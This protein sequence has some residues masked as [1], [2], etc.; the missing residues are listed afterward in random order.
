M[1]Y[2]S[3]GWGMSNAPHAYTIVVGRD[4][5]WMCLGIDYVAPWF[6]AEA[7]KVFRDRQKPNGQ[8][9]EY[10]DMES[11]AVDDYG[12]NLADNTPLYAWA[13]NQHWQHFAE[14]GFYTAF[15]PSMQRAGAYLLD[16]IGPDDLLTSIPNG[17]GM[18]GITSWRNIIDGAVIAGQVTEI[19]A[20]AVL[21]LRQIAAFTGESHFATAAERIT[22]AINAHL[23][24]ETHYLL[25][26]SGEARNAQ[27]TGDQVF[28]L[29]AGVA[30]RERHLA[31]L[32]RLWQADFRSERGLRTVPTIDP[33]YSPT[34]HFG[35][36][37]GSW[38]N[39]TLWYA[40]VAAEYGPD[41]A[42]AAL[43]MVGYPV[44]TEQDAAMN[45]HPGEFPE[46]FHG[47]SGENLGMH[48]SPWVAP[49]FIWALLEGLLGLTWAHGT[50][51]FAPHWPDGWDEV[52]ITRLPTGMGE[53]DV[54]LTPAACEI[55]PH[56]APV[57]PV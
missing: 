56:A 32:D 35:L 45:I 14:E 12:L 26:R 21:G 43:E 17:T 53:V 13:V 24:E 34:A 28:P 46:W 8:I 9:L 27:C 57:M 31:L 22:H 48:L 15:L 37:G 33:A 19:N 55:H 38:P 36:V 50:P 1:R 41:R 16:A 11:G 52:T 42:L 44:I 51:H 5:G 49:T 7:L 47:E 39:L 6:A 3:L 4:T 54:H 20:L 40:A 2:Y 18:Y 10:V 25:C 29:L 23:W 30:P